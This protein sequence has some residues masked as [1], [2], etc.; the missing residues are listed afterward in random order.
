MMGPSLPLPPGTEN[1]ISPDVP[2]PPGTEHVMDPG[3][4][5]PPGTEDVGVPCLTLP[6]GAEDPLSSDLPL[7]PGTEDVA[8]ASLPLPPGT[9]D[10][11]TSDLPL[12]PGTE[13]E[14]HMLVGSGL[15]V[16]STKSKTV[17]LQDIAQKSKLGSDMTI[18]GTHFGAQ[19]LSS[20]AWSSGSN[21]QDGFGLPAFMTGMH[22]NPI[23]PPPGTEDEHDL[24]ASMNVLPPLGIR[25]NIASQFATE[26]ALT[27]SQTTTVCMSS[28]TAP[29]L[30]LHT[31]NPLWNTSSNPEGMEHTGTTW[32][33]DPS[34]V[35]DMPTV[36]RKS[37]I[38]REFTPPPPGTEMDDLNKSDSHPEL[39]EA[40]ME[41]S[42]ESDD[43]CLQDKKESTPPPPGT[44][45]SSESMAIGE[46]KSSKSIISTLELT[47]R[48]DTKIRDPSLS[49]DFN[50][51]SLD[52]Q[53]SLPQSKK[54]E[55]I[56]ST[57]NMA[58][59]PNLSNVNVSKIGKRSCSTEDKE[60][61]E[62]K[63]SEKTKVSKAKDKVDDERMQT[64]GNMSKEQGPPQQ[65]HK[66]P[67]IGKPSKKESEEVEHGKEGRQESESKAKQRKTS[68]RSR[69]STEEPQYLQ[70]VEEER[71]FPGNTE[72]KSSTP[73]KSTRTGKTEKSEEEEIE[74]EAKINEESSMKHRKS[75]KKSKE[76]REGVDDLKLAADTDASASQEETQ[77]MKKSSRSG[78]STKKDKEEND[79]DVPVKETKQRKRSTRSSSDDQPSEKGSSTPRRKSRS[80]RAAIPEEREEDFESVLSPQEMNENAEESEKANSSDVDDEQET[81]SE[82]V[83]QQRTRAVRR[84]VSEDQTYEALSP[85]K[86]SR[87]SKSSVSEEEEP[88]PR[89]ST[90]T[91]RASITE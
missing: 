43:E 37:H 75:S 66:A 58:D 83:P 53:V 67:R 63:F 87:K 21:S 17:H 86:R 31:Q 89:R 33:T 24:H 51:Q 22:E 12:P 59:S 54:E 7:P 40:S 44:E 90:R 38:D 88:P 5:L 1:I 4:P 49:V 23:P 64:E 6:P 34:A 46:S 16:S 56:K 78:R 91:T 47:T 61:E 15:G 77:T 50:A 39:G 2:L 76:R 74:L 27:A 65:S 55:S 29:K 68:R 84:L 35:M 9:E 10:A 79:Q 52:T 69:D 82:T 41:L 25:D 60:R 26:K 73:K 18:P 32:P 42:D 14:A 3:L 81:D 72:V 85:R 48:L 13:D 8:I 62:K 45:S 28:F 70:P 30:G 20:G 71:E 36:A 57:E 11:L 80:V 19:E